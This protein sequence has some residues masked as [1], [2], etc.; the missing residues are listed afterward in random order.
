MPI[1]A[2]HPCSHPGC[3]VL[4]GRGQARCATHERAA[5]A[6][7]RQNDTSQALY[8]TSKWRAFSKAWLAGHPLCAECARA[9]RVTAATD[10]DHVEPHRGDL[11]KFWGGPFQSLCASCHSRKTATT[12]RVQR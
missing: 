10:C 6:F 1:S 11:T 4:L 8:N 12:D 3:P 5:Q 2:P 9:G 7:R